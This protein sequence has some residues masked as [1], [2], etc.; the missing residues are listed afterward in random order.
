MKNKIS[1]IEEE[2]SGKEDEIET[3]NNEMLKEEI[4][5]D[6]LELTKIQEKIKEVQKSIDEKMSEWEELNETL[7]KYV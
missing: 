2:I 1:K 3:L 4:C 7:N 5:S 6:Y